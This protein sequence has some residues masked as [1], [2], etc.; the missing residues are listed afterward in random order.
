LLFTATLGYTSTDSGIE[1][2][3]AFRRP[4]EAL[5]F[6]F[7]FCEGDSMVGGKSLRLLLVCCGTSMPWAGTALFAQGTQRVSV[8]TSSAQANALSAGTSM[9]PDGR[10]VVFNSA[11]TNLSGSDSAYFD[12]FVRDR[13]TGTTTLVSVPDVTTGQVM[14]NSASFVGRSGTR[15][16]SDDGRYV[17]FESDASNLVL[18]DT[19]GLTDVFVRDLVAN[20]TVRVSVRSNEAQ[21]LPVCLNDICTGHS[22]NGSI[23]ADGRFVAFQ[24]EYEFTSD[25]AAF[26]D[27]YVRDR[28]HDNDGI[29]DEAGSQGIIDQATTIQ[30]SRRQCDLQGFPCNNSV[31]GLSYDPA[32]SGN[33]RYVAFV[34]R[35]ANIIIYTSDTN[36]AD[37][38]FVYDLQNPN[39]PPVRVS[40][41]SAEGQSQNNLDN[42]APSISYSGRYVAFASAANDLVAGDGNG[43]RDIFVRDRDADNDNIFDE[44]VSSNTERVSLGYSAFPIPGGSTVELNGFSTAPAVSDDGR[45]VA[46]QSDANNYNCGILIGSCL[47]QNE[48]T[49]VF[50]RD[51][52]LGVTS[53][54]SLTHGGGESNG[55]SISPF[56]SADGQTVSFISVGTNVVT[57]DN[58]G[59][60][61]DIYVRTVSGAP[62]V[63]S[64]VSRRMHGAVGNFDINLPLGS[65]DV[66]CRSGGATTVLVTFSEPVVLAGGPIATTQNIVVQSH[67]IVGNVLALNCYGGT[68]QTCAQI[69]L[70]NLVDLQGNSLAGERIIRVILLIGDVNADKQVASGDITQVK[71]VS[72]A[73]TSAANF[74]RDVNCDGQIASGDITQVKSRSGQ[75]VLCP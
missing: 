31:E 65:G 24:S 23:S 53:R 11:A 45:Y 49:D 64:A 30:A 61:A 59:A 8:A 13:L 72:G 22:R 74:R 21:S 32:I 20:R 66:E 43:N 52:I 75:S 9:T 15:H 50:V 6:T 38:V 56:I 73:V 1:L 37:D 60:L 25:D 27:I 54:A 33:G 67:A 19:N 48:K 29:F 41:D 57:P 70:G 10:F 39:A 28:D 17:V 18:N 34:S 46:F 14:A 26:Q 51:R 3:W 69:T 40:V 68:N 4:E 2:L 35:S 36:N 55:N 71:A 58:N 62:T 7:H 44:A 12:V 5:T 42:L 63:V 47:D 16:I